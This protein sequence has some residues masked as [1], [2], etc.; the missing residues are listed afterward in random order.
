MVQCKKNQ[1]GAHPGPAK[2]CVTLG[3]VA[4][5][6]C[7]MNGLEWI[8]QSIVIICNSLIPLMF[9]WHQWRFPS[10]CLEHCL[11]F[12][13]S[14]RGLFFGQQYVVFMADVF[15]FLQ[16]L[17]FLLMP[18]SLVW[19]NSTS[20]KAK[21]QPELVMQVRGSEVR[22]LGGRGLIWIRHGARPGQGN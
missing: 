7:N 14:A 20:Q 15:F 21:C 3:Q 1:T 17:G 5:R 4:S 6:F 10:S 22:V 12:K 13:M 19:L 9:V 8:S 18:V 11:L 2:L 16:F